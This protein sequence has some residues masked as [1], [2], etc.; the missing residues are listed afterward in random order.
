MR[1][2]KALTIARSDSRG[3][4]GIQADLKSFS[5]RRVYGT[6]VITAVAAQNTVAMTHVEGLSRDSVTAQIR[7]VLDDLDHA[8]TPPP[9]SQVILCCRS[10]QRAWQ[11]AKH[12]SSW[13][14]GRIALLATG[15][16]HP[17]DTR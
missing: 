8:F 3:G 9:H 2:A 16:I 10:G 15:T 17:T 5:A 14:H 12:L 11:A 7:A 4:A 1:I 6:S 13:W